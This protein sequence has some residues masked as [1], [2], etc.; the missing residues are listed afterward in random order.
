MPPSKA[1]KQAAAAATK[2]IE[3]KTFGMKNKNKSKKVANYMAQA[4]GNQHEDK[5]KRAK[6]KARAEQ[7]ALDAMLF[8]EATK[9]KKKQEE[10]KVV[11]KV[12]EEPVPTE[13]TDLIE[14][15]RKR[16]TSRTPVTLDRLTAW[17]QA[18]RDARAA[19]QSTKMTN[20]QAA[21]K[22]G[23]RVQGLTG[24]DLLTLDPTIFVDDAEANEDRLEERVGTDDEEEDD[25][26]EGGAG[27]APEQAAAS[28]AAARSASA[29]AEPSSAPPA[30]PA[31]SEGVEGITA[32]AKLVDLN[33]V[34]ESLFLD[35]D[36]P[37]DD[38]LA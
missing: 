33:G 29:A 37:D 19:A 36:L 10:V 30:E 1:D 21:H 6:D 34:D 27:G 7:D 8:K 4:Q 2:K 25:E 35:D 14:Y 20:A 3:D 11:E 23:K 22:S 26:G 13:L 31:S 5:G 28:P 38:E 32:A 18:K 17:L 12:V 9:K 16:L 24:R 15:K